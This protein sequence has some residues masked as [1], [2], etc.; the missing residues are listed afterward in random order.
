MMKKGTRLL[1]SNEVSP[2]QTKPNDT[3][4]DSISSRSVISSGLVKRLTMVKKKTGT[5]QTKH[6][7]MA[8]SIAIILSNLSNDEEYIR[9][10]LGVDNWASKEPSMKDIK[11]IEETK[12]LPSS[13]IS[14]VEDATEIELS[15]SH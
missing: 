4:R 7:E 3:D 15:D 1:T 11:S 5:T 6:T 9:T 14:H 2:Y 12:G 10:L 13:S 8:L